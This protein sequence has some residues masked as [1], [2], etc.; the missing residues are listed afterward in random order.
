MLKASD[1]VEISDTITA[2]VATDSFRM[3]KKCNG[4]FTLT[5]IFKKEK[6]MIFLF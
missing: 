5:V 2:T 1:M 4:K 6:F 3:T